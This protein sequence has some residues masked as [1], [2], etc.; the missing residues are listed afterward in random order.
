MKVLAIDDEEIALEGVG[1]SYPGGRAFG[2][3]S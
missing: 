3:D 2:G 1:G